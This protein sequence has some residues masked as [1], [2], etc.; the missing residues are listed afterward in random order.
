MEACVILLRQWQLEDDR[1][2]EKQ[3]QMLLEL[4]NLAKD[5]FMDSMNGQSD[6]LRKVYE[7]LS[8]EF[9][10]EEKL[11]QAS[12]ARITCWTPEQIR[13][14]QIINKMSKETPC[15]KAYYDLSV[16]L[17]KKSQALNAAENE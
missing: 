16:I 11:K 3:R 14:A 2:R 15:M 1:R 12:K 9:T 6:R 5:G 17:E 4:Y 13:F 8:I 10:D 7:I